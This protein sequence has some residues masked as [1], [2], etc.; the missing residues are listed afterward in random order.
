MANNIDT[1]ELS[2]DLSEK[3]NYEITVTGKLSS[4]S[5]NTHIARI[6]GMLE[7][8]IENDVPED[9]EVREIEVLFDPWERPT[10]RVWCK[11]DGFDHKNSRAFTQTFMTNG[12]LYHCQVDVR[13][14]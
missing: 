3:Y 8:V 14:F 2:R 11:N 10:V 9:E 12:R 13:P 5:E 6:E 1:T 4:L 7:K